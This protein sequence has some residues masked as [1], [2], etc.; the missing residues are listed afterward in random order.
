MGQIPQDLKQIQSAG[1]TAWWR[2]LE[3]DGAALYRLGARHKAKSLD[4]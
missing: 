1:N 4:Y 2:A 3:K